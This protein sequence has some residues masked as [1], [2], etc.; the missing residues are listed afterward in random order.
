L[1]SLP[2]VLWVTSVPE[3]A[4]ADRTSLRMGVKIP[5]IQTLF[6]KDGAVAVP[7]SYNYQD[8][9]TNIDCAAHSI[10]DGT[11]KLNLTVTDSSIYFPD[12]DKATIPMTPSV[13]SFRNFTSSF[14]ILLRD[15]QTAQYTT[16]TDQVSGEVL[17]VDATLNVL[18]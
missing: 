6:G 5:V 7:A 14:N 16:A 12:K 1:S 9:G 15:G 18:K 8:V 13:P 17:K 3:G 4:A 10:G 11:F 2:Y